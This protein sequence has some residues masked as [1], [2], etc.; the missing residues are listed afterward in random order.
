MKAL[1]ALTCAAVLGA[2]G[3]FFWGEYEA[4][5]ERERIAH[6]E[7][8]RSACLDQLGQFA[9]DNYRGD[10]TPDQR[11]AVM[12]CAGYITPDDVEAAGRSL[13]AAP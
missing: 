1:V 4:A 2:I 12:D 6:F 3:Y 5:Q 11:A 13:L 9:A 7:A 8:A 10:A